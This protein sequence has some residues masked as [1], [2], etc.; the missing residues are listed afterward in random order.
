MSDQKPWLDAHVVPLC[1]ASPKLLIH[2]AIHQESA[3]GEGGAPRISEILVWLLAEDGDG[4]PLAV[5]RLLEGGFF[6]DYFREAALVPLTPE[7]TVQI[8]GGDGAPFI[9]T[10]GMAS[11]RLW[12]RIAEVNTVLEVGHVYPAA[13]AAAAAVKRLYSHFEG[14][15]PMDLL[16]RYRPPFGG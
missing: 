11:V 5:A 7:R 4:W 8:F 1:S 13:T 10:N 2:S 14:I 6:F 15:S 12:K 16:A 9:H 3:S